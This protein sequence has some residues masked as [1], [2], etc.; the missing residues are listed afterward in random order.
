MV[1]ISLGL[2]TFKLSNTKHTYAHKTEKNTHTPTHTHTHT[3]PHT[4]THTHTLIRPISAGSG[5]WRR[6]RL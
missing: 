3:V 4:H 2:Q 1:D 6:H 5:N